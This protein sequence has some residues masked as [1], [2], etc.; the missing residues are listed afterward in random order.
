MGKILC[1]TRGGEES[2][3]TRAAAIELARRQNDSLVFFFV[4]DLRFLDRI[5]APVVVDVAAELEALGRFQLSV[6]CE[7]AAVQQVGA[8]SVVRRGNLETELCAVTNEL[9][10]TL[11]V[12]GRPQGAGAVFDESAFASFAAR[13]R[14][15]TGVEVCVL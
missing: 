8:T 1:A 5:A 6:A 14:A 15:R 10:A 3:A 11:I 4:A 9:G 2:E 12:L 13:I 7:Q